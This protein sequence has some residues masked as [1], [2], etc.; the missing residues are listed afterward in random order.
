MR[1]W[2][3]L[4]F[5]Y[6]QGNGYI[7]STSCKY[8]NTPFLNPVNKAWTKAEI[9]MNSKDNMLGFENVML[10]LSLNSDS[11]ICFEN[12]CCLAQPC[13]ALAYSVF[14]FLSRWLR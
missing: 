11:A 14:L 2:E 12:P 1:V 3:R 8:V 7:L 6:R 13:S 10:N 4:G 5:C 9:A